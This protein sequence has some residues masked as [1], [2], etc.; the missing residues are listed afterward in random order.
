MRMQPING[1]CSSCLSVT[2]PNPAEVLAS[3]PAYRRQMTVSE[4][5]LQTGNT[6][7]RLAARNAAQ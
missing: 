2:L 1:Y 3:S 6:H 4:R 7:K 5:G